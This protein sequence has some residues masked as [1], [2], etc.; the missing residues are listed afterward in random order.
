MKRNILFTGLLIISIFV[1][2]NAIVHPINLI[3]SDMEGYY[4]YLPSTFID[5]SF[6]RSVVRDT[7]YLKEYKDTGKTYTKYTC[8]IAILQLPF[9]LLTHTYAHLFGKNTDG[10]NETYGRGLAWAGLFYFWVGIY[11][12]YKLGQ[13]YF[14]NVTV[15]FALVGLACGTNLYYYT[16]FQPAMSHV[17]SFCLFAIFL[18][19]T[20]LMW[21][22]RLGHDKIMSWVTYGLLMGLI[23][24]VRPT[25]IIIAIL[26]LYIWQKNTPH[27]IDYVIK[28]DKMISL[29]VIACVI[30]WIPQFVYWH[31]ISGDWIIWSYTDEG[32]PFWREPKLIRVLFDPWNGWILYSPIVVFPLVYLLYRRNDNSHYERAYILIFMLATY[33]FSS[34]WAW[35]FG[36]AFGH[37]SYV[38]FTS[39]LMIPFAGMLHAISRWKWMFYSMVAAI[40]ILCY[41]NVG[42]TYAYQPPWDGYSWT[43]NSWWGEV[44]KLFS[45]V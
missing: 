1:S 33:I 21:I 22:N 40:L 6:G 5:G 44:K 39:L 26:P 7:T 3:W 18:W 13:K 43:Y 41:Y 28:Y 31:Y 16:F 12:L 45:I 25:N 17:Y 37:R 24:L 2:K 15:I 19:L 32:F 4:T 42:L 8:G 9:F 38:E 30:P 36:G 34:W 35:W 14:S 10:K 11:V 23:V 20:D 27:K 29:M